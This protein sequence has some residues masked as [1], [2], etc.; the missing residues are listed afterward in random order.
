MF[1]V[2]FRFVQIWTEAITHR[3][4]IQVIHIG[5]M[6]LSTKI[7]KFTL[8]L[9]EFSLCT[10]NFHSLKLIYY[11]CTICRYVVGTASQQNSIRPPLKLYRFVAHFFFVFYFRLANTIKL[12]MFIH[13]SPLS[14][15]AVSLP[16]F[17]CNTRTRSF[18]H[19]RTALVAGQLQR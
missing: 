10:T 12:I 1:Y 19:R 5:Q 15:A 9:I 6:F 16:R 4:T 8:I 7:N 11:I 17:P 3:S 13:S 2:V 14:A 18:W